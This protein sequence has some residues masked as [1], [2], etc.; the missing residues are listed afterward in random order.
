M[1]LSL[2]EHLAH[3]LTRVDRAAL[4]LATAQT[5]TL[6]WLGSALAGTQTSPGQS[7]LDYAAAQPPMEQATGAAV[8]GL[9]CPSTSSGRSAE[10]AA[11]VNGGLSH[12]VEMDDLDRGSVL[13]PGAVVIPAALA[14]AQRERR[15][16]RAFLEAAV[17][18][19]EVAIRV[20]EA[21]GRTHY[22]YFHNTATCGVFGAAAAAASLLGL[23]EEQIVWALGSAG[24]MSAGLWEFNRDG[25]MSKHLHAGRAAQTGVLAADLARRGFTGAR[26]IL[27]GERGFFAATSTDADPA[28]VLDGLDP[29]M[30]AWKM[31][32]VS[33]KPH[34]SCRHTHP[35]IDAA[36]ALRVRLTAERA[37]D[38]EDN[39]YR[40]S[41]LSASSA[42]NDS[43]VHR[44]VRRIE[45]ETYQA[46]LD[47]C[48]NPAPST[49]YQAKFSLQY[50]V[51]S[52]LA[53]GHAALADFAPARIAD[54]QTAALIAHTT[55]RHNNLFETMYPRQWPSNVTVA[56]ADGRVLSQT[57]NTPK[58]DPE[59]PL[60]QS[61]LEGKFRQMLSDT[62]FAETSEGWLAFA[63][64][65]GEAP[66]VILPQA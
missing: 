60:S 7:L 18:G 43:L 65:L 30:G 24:T 56:C 23:S 64:R 11:L 61:E 25:A 62:P 19:Y 46:A 3:F 40:V 20:G 33:I 1:S 54:P 39:Q 17:L 36:L 59:N 22:R 9:P 52:A 35:A 66:R 10:V 53:R 45:I 58:G 49:P 48:D 13:H 5:Y 14:V 51:A 44:A 27:E 37:E 42:V 29:Q 32:G 21:V 6:D 31:S 26:A 63:A 2:T 47:L 38:A 12:I 28:R 15:S 55:L 50:C 57:I 8:I 41:A 16:G 4:P 34:A